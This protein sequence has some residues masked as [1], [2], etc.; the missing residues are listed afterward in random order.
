L[1]AQEAKLQVQLDVD[2]AADTEEL[3]ELTA[4]LRRHLLELDVESV[5]RPRGTPPP[6]GARAAEAADLGTLLV[7]LA[8]TPALLG[9]VVNT[10]R[11]WLSRGRDR[12]VK[13]KLGDD[14]L[15]VTQ[16]SSE[17]QERLIADWI[18]RHAEG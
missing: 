3:D 1:P 17:Q 12:G 13:L 2:P 7:T 15:E 4:G 16:I 9:A 18:A 10:V 8:T 11:A 5:E 14:V 6:S